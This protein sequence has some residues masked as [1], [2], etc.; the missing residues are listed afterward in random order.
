[1]VTCLEAPLQLTANHGVLGKLSVVGVRYRTRLSIISPIALVS[2]ANR[3]E[4]K[5]L[6]VIERE[7]AGGYVT[8]SV[9]LSPQS[10]K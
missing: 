2:Y 10:L 4:T 5:T 7:W 3:F 6:T 8:N 9:I 1:M